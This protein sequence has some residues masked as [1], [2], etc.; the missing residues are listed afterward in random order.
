MRPLLTK[1]KVFSAIMW[2]VAIALV[3][4][5]ISLGMTRAMF[6][7]IVG[8]GLFLIVTM[9]EHERFPLVTGL[10]ALLVSA[11]LFAIAFVVGS[12]NLSRFIEMLIIGSDPPYLLSWASA[13]GTFGVLVIITA[14]FLRNASM[15][16]RGDR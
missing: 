3:I 16:G 10:W 14:P 1:S 7:G 11:C 4:V 13:A 15:S 2:L 6:G 5:G 8:V 12:F 9:V